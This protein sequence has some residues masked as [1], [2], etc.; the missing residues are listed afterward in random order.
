[1]QYIKLMRRNQSKAVAYRTLGKSLRL[2]KLIVDNVKTV[3]IPKNKHIKYILLILYRK[4]E[5][6][7]LHRPTL[8]LVASR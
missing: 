6:K 4:K 7:N 8:S 2:S 5:K 1:M 3:V